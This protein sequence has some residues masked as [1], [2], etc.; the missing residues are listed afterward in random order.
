MLKKGLKSGVGIWLIAAAAMLAATVISGC[1]GGYGR[2]HRD[3]AVTAVFK[4]GRF[5]SDYKFY[6]IGRESL[7]YAVVGIRDGYEFRSR[8]WKP[9]DPGTETFRKMVAH[10]YGFQESAPYGAYI[11]DSDGKRVGIWFSSFDLTTV[12]VT[13]DGGVYVHNPYLPSGNMDASPLKED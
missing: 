2:L 6:Y 11:L 12:R 4:E 8:F 3:P 1:A 5:Q 9:I 13:Q 10:P 7:P